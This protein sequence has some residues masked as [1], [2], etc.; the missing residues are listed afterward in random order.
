MAGGI[1][2]YLVQ[3]MTTTPR[4]SGTI[5]LTTHALYW[6]Q[7]SS[8]RQRV[9]S[10]IGGEPVKLKKFELLYTPP[11]GDEVESEWHVE[12]CRAGPWG[13]GVTDSGLRIR[14]HGR[15]KDGKVADFELRYNFPMNTELRDTFVAAVVEVLA[16]HAFSVKRLNQPP[17][18]LPPAVSAAV[19][20]AVVRQRAARSLASHGGPNR[21]R[22][23]FSVVEAE[24]QDSLLPQQ[25]A[26]LLIFADERE[27]RAAEAVAAAFATDR[28]Q[29]NQGG[30]LE[31][32]R[33]GSRETLLDPS[34]LDPTVA[35]ASAAQRH[36]R[37]LLPRSGSLEALD[38]RSGESRTTE[39]S[40]A[41]KRA[42]EM[43][44]K[45]M[46]AADAVAA[47]AAKRREL[48]KGTERAQATFA[49]LPFDEEKRIRRIKHN[50]RLISSLITVP[51]QHLRD[52][53]YSL[54]GW[55]NPGTSGA[56]F[57][58]LQV[59][60]L[61]DMLHYTPAVMILAAAA[62][63]METQKRKSRDYRSF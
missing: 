33:T 2:S 29:R 25:L 31:I 38:S 14:R 40:G 53:V 34:L 60:V 46:N 21:C 42:N 28:E 50:L 36:P 20:G 58:L 3:D 30:S 39:I 48:A 27:H 7:N 63:V 49:A 19:V 5:I 44:S 59:M 62:N 15:G 23:P 54:L 11:Q 56:L 22:L 1:P 16:A 18:V 35:D 47:A 10:K 12:A 6:R 37:S 4:T 13:L 17:G 8:I 26:E 55:E 43:D 61:F 52:A 51:V 32:S 57:S 24:P 41:E 9:S 45:E